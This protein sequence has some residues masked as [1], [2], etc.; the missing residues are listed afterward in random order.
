VDR[1]IVVRGEGEVRT[2]PDRATVLVTVDGE[3]ESREE[4]YEAAATLVA[5][6]DALFTREADGLDRVVTTA[7]VV[8]PRTR[9]RKGESVRTGWR[10]SRTTVVEIVALDRV[11]ALLAEIVAAGGAIAGPSWQLAAGHPA[12]DEARRAAAT[13]ARR[14]ADAYAASLGL[15][16][17]S[18]AWVA[19]PGLRPGTPGIAYGA[20]RMAARG[21][22]AS[23]APMSDEPIEVNPDE[24]TV[25]AEVEVAFVIDDR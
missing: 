1:E 22:A 21:P 13:D 7:L 18:V 6:V 4:A 16:V 2:L 12:H 25:H 17:G 11:G 19:E 5:N 8:Q 20:A 9:W 24:I 15:A 10:S 14:R 3:G 23:G